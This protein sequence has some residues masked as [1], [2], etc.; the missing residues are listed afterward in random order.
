LLRV[1]F[2]AVILSCLVLLLPQVAFATT[3]VETLDTTDSFRYP[4]QRKSFTT[5]AGVQFVFY[6]SDTA[7]LVYYETSSDNGATWGGKTSSGATSDDSSPVYS[8]YYSGGYVYLAWNYRTG[9]TEFAYFRRGAI[10]GTA[11]TWS[12]SYY[13]NLNGTDVAG[14]SV[15]ADTSGIPWVMTRLST[16][17]TVASKAQFADG[18]GT[19]ATTSLGASYAVE[20][21]PLVTSNAVVAIWRA[22]ANVLTV[23]RW[24]GG[25]WNAAVATDACI[26]FSATVQGD[27]VHIVYTK[28]TSY[29]V[30]YRSW[31]YNA[32]SASTT[33]QAGT[34]STSYPSITRD[35]T[36]NNLHVF[37]ENSPTDDHI[38]YNRY[39]ATV[40]NWTG[41]YDLVNEA[42]GDL[43]PANGYYLNSDLTTDEDHLGIY[44]AAGAGTILKFK[45][46]Q[47]PFEV[48]TLY[49][50][51]IND[52]YAT[53]Y[54]SIDSLS[55]GSATTIGFI[56][57][58]GADPLGGG[59]TDLHEHGTYA[60]A[61]Y[62]LTTLPTLTPSTLYGFR[63]Y[64]TNAFGT[65]YGELE[66]FYTLALPAPTPTPTPTPYPEMPP[67]SACT[68][69]PDVATKPATYVSTTTARLNAYLSS[70]G[71]G[72]TY[73]RFQYYTGGG[74]WTDNETDWV[75][76]YWDG[77]P[78]AY[79]NISG[80]STNTTYN[81]RAQAVNPCGPDDGATLQF[82][83]GLNVGAPSQ[84]L[85]VP[86]IKEPTI[87]LDW[88]KGTYAPYTMIRY[89]FGSYPGNSTDGML[90]IVVK[91]NSYIHEGLDYGKTYYYGAWGSS[92]SV[93][94]NL[95]ATFA[96][97]MATTWSPGAIPTPTTPGT[98]GN[99]FF[100]IDYTTQDGLPI[101][102]AVNDAINALGMPLT[103]GWFLGALM[104][105]MGLGF[106]GYR[107]AENLGQ[108][109]A[110]I[111][112][113][114]MF[115]AAVAVATDARL[116]PGFVTM[117][118]LI[119]SIGFVAIRRGA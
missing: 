12:A 52:V 56:Y 112:G 78:N 104:L 109:T 30:C 32:F 37:W 65:V 76:G 58:A 60:A 88:R 116:V 6:W 117:L 71:G 87:D 107:I 2:I 90:A 67:G 73:I 46:L 108:G 34:T 28:T 35:T 13:A 15:C 51:G 114:V 11:I 102:D 103:T 96:T 84:F 98:P 9:G 68:V 106:A 82:T 118:F 29:N 53:L 119:T 38:Y 80:L 100:S 26:G 4:N 81:F 40:G 44:Y 50:D 47:E 66:I 72:E 5:E 94:T 105:C 41:S 21:V 39:V 19:W 59:A 64:A 97:G 92:D 62:Y 3:I 85:A 16:T 18:S 61:T 57:K 10:S 70:D 22:N 17:A 86:S 48:T 49:A 69:A 91:G 111:V 93:G 74:T 95:S 113:I 14:I 31:E 27:K 63:A 55:F 23:Q 43:L 79:V 1:L 83:T 89:K 99:W 36:T 33:L 75:G 110:I 101:Y 115:M 7:N 42:T 25:A 77:N 8:V 24:D 45:Y 54:G 20:I